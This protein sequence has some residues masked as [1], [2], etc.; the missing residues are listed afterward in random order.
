LF[1]TQITLFPA[2][3]ASLRRQ[4]AELLVEAFP[5]NNGWSTLAGA[6][7]EVDESILPTHRTIAALDGNQ[8][9]GWV[10]ARP[11][12]RGRVWEL[13]PLVVRAGLRGRGIGRALVDELDR[14][15][16]AAG[17]LTMI[18]GVDDDVGVTSLGGV[19]LYPAPLDHLRALTAPPEHPLGFY[20]R[21][22][23]VMSGV[24][25]DANG[26]GLPDFTVSRRIPY[27]S[28]AE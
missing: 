20:L 8:L 15:V 19:D 25:P 10:G 16:A 26:F 6:I 1:P 12:Y 21:M 22:G 24:I 2:D 13:H 4:A 27:R 9:A 11:S 17:G 14:T 3:D 23:F 5:Y 18:V 28:P 7:E